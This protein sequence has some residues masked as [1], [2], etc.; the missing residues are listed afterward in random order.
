MV[1]YYDKQ[2]NI[3]TK[4]VDVPKEK[5]NIDESTIQNSKINENLMNITFEKQKTQYPKRGKK[6][7]R[8]LKRL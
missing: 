7:R 2:T 8:I 1:D 6:S 3:L 5:M 4:D